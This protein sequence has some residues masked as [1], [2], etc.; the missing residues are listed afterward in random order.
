[1]GVS[2][3][4]RIAIA[5]IAIA[6]LS[7]AALVLAMQ[8]SSAPSSNC[9]ECAY[10]VVPNRWFYQHGISRGRIVKE[11]DSASKED[12]LDKPFT[13]LLHEI[14]ANGKCLCWCDNCQKWYLLDAPGGTC[15]GACATCGGAVQISALNH[16][17][18]N[19]DIACESGLNGV[20]L[21]SFG[22][23]A[24][25]DWPDECH[26]EL[27]TEIVLYCKDRGIEV[28]PAMFE[29]GSDID[30]LGHDRNFAA[31]LPTTLHLQVIELQNDSS[32]PSRG[33]VPVPGPEGNLIRNGDLE[34]YDDFGNLVYFWQE[35]ASM[36]PTLVQDTAVHGNSSM[37]FGGFTSANLDL[38]GIIRQAVSVK[39]NRCYRLTFQIR[40]E[41]FEPVSKLVAGVHA[42]DTAAIAQG[43]WVSLVE[44]QPDV[45]ETDDWETVTLDFHNQSN[46]VVTVFIGT[47]QGVQ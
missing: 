25:T 41:G 34:E 4:K 44:V 36:K 17:K 24:I 12:Q 29:P 23:D 6:V 14:L 5:T 1:M 18:G 47:R 3:K 40:T 10:S 35:R 9:A 38:Y 45:E 37:R 22:L 42:G 27:F 46:Q 16:V 39:P 30:A 11:L 19:I 7:A 28:I 26:M 13:T 31:A 15:P 32:V 43:D 2:M 33:L 20:V 8:L 21:S